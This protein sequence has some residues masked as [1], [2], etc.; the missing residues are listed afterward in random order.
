MPY[1]ILDSKMVLGGKLLIAILN[2]T[3]D[4]M[5]GIQEQIFQ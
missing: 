1:K 2:T 4:T 5:L 3:G